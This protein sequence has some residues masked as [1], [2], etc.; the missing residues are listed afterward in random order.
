[1]F[2]YNLKVKIVYKKRY[3]KLVLDNNISQ[4][5]NQ[6]KYNLLK[7]IIILCLIVYYQRNI[8]FLIN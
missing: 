7:Y 5:I 3:R 8:I 6:K 4:Q 1:M 2:L